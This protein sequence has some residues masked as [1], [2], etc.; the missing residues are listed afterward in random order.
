MYLLLWCRGHHSETLLWTSNFDGIA[1]D[2]RHRT[3]NNNKL[4]L[5]K[6]FLPRRYKTFMSHF[7]S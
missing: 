1:A 6:T 2:T 5:Y 4:D 7:K 3:I